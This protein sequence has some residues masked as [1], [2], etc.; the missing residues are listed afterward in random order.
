MNFSL[1]KQYINHI[2]HYISNHI[3]DPIDIAPFLDLHQASLKEKQFIFNVETL[4]TLSLQFLKRVFLINFSHFF[5]NIIKD[6]GR[7]QHITNHSEAAVYRYF[8][9]ELHLKFRESLLEI[10]VDEL[11]F[12]NVIIIG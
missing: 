1:D 4:F 8:V 11:I 12:A 2:D 3:D 6:G 10:H 7:N 5:V 9:K